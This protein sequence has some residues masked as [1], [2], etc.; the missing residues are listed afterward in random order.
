MAKLENFR[1]AAQI[2]DPTF[3]NNGFFGILSLVS[4]G[5]P[6]TDSSI[7]DS[8]NFILSNQ[9][10]NGGWS[11]AAGTDSDT[12][13]TAAA[14]LALTAA[15][16][17]AADSHIISA[18]NYIKAPQNSDGG[19][20]SNPSYDALSNHSFTSWILWALKAAGVDKSAWTQ[21]SNTPLSFL[22][23]YQNQDGSFKWEAADTTMYPTTAAD[24]VIAMAGKTLSLNKISQTLPTVNFRIEDSANTI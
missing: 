1:I 21:G 24:A 2:G 15:G 8:K 18:L 19:F 17:P 5:V 6:V 20:P 3:L 16:V 9:N 10:T 11:Y 23:S 4:A 22:A 13:D 14:I 12:D 7:T